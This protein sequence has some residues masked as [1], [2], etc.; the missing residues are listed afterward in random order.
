MRTSSR[1][2][3]KL[4]TRK[5]Q[6]CVCWGR[7]TQTYRHRHTDT[8]THTRTH[9]RTHA[10]THRHT[11][12]DR[13]HSNTHS[14]TP[15]LTLSLTYTHSP[16]CPMLSSLLL[17]PLYLAGEAVIGAPTKPGFLLLNIFRGDNLPAANTNGFS[18]PYVSIECEGRKKKT[19]V[20]GGGCEWRRRTENWRL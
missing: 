10:Q 2:S 16:L 9:A 1:P 8:D 15:S 12:T 18:D 4:K 20:C 13:E 11:R 14:P 5:H 3:L 19:Q 6:V 7:D 17:P